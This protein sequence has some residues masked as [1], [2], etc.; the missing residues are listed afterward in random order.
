[1]VY[2]NPYYYKY[3]GYVIHLCNSNYEN[4]FNAPIVDTG[5]EKDNINSVC[6]YRNINNR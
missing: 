6:I 1:M 2:C 3:V 4:D 5:I